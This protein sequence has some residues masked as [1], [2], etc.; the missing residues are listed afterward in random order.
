MVVHLLVSGGG[1]GNEMGA[2]IEITGGTFTV[3]GT[4][5]VLSNK[6][7]NSITGGNVGKYNKLSL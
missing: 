1:I 3:D 7:G 5:N 4:A 6:G 2:P